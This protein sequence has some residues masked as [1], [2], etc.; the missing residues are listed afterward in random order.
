MKI[1]VDTREQ[2]PWFTN[3]S[4]FTTIKKKLECGDYSVEGHEDTF[5]VERKSKSDAYGTLGK[6]R[7]MFE[8]MLEKTRHY[9]FFA[10]IIESSLADFIQN[11]PIQTKMSPAAAVQSLIAFSL[12]YNVRVVWGENRILSQRYAESYMKHYLKYISNGKLI[13]RDKSI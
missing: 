8:R 5:G 12:K 3:T 4:K 1:I 10:I 7:A 13:R 11:P 6:G 9:T 2:R